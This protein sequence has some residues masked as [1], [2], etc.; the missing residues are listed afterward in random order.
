ML[1][2]LALLLLTALPVLPAQAQ[3]TPTAR[4]AQVDTSA[5]PVVKLYVSVTDANG[6]PTPGLLARDFAITEDGQPISIDEFVGGG[7]GS[8]DTVL[9]IDRSGSM[10]E[11]DK[12]DGAKEAARAFVRQMRPG[13]RTAVIA[14]SNAP[15]LVQPFTGDTDLLDRAI[16]R[17]RPDGSTALYD[18]LIAG[19]QQLKGLGGRRALL[20]LTDGRDVRVAGDPTPASRATLDQAIQVATSEGI[21]VQSIGLGDRDTTDLRGGIDETVLKR[22]ADET[23]GAYF[24][25]PDADQ[26]TD[27]YRRLSADMQ[28]EYVI[29][30]RSPRPFYDGTRRDIHVSVGGAPAASGAYTERHL[31]NVHS[32]PA[33]GL[34]L[35]LPILA[36][37]LL[38]ALLRRRPTNDQRPTT[39]D[40]RPTPQTGGLPATGPRAV[41]ALGGSAAT[42]P[43]MADGPTLLKP[44]EG[45]TV[46]ASDAERCRACA[47][48]LAGPGAR[49]CMACG[50]AQSQVAPAARPERATSQRFFCDQCGR[51]LREGARFCA[52]CGATAPLPVIRDA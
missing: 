4:V 11:N 35:L 14:F 8:I 36:A 31:I 3:A 19:V 40:Q 15:D 39:N 16:R 37:L 30:Y 7:A 25:A 23:G 28:Q 9:V 27:L 42:M 44:A 22:I 34:L 29:T 5:Y 2:P 52:M 13:D 32:D 51:P 17:I 48:P 43:A 47:A 46:L 21:S 26:L 20:L 45:V 1:L 24:Y 50:V 49:F 10:D 18:S 41:S 6:K 12:I 33:V 38:P